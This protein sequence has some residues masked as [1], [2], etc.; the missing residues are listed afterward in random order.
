MRTRSH[1]FNLEC[2]SACTLHRLRASIGHSLLRCKFNENNGSAR[3][4]P[5]PMTRANTIQQ[6]LAFFEALA[7][8]GVFVRHRHVSSTLLV[9]T[10]YS[11]RILCACKC[12][13]KS[14]NTKY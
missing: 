7:V 11:Y 12:N 13:Q 3:T 5:M 6:P 9:L 14:Y 1:M 10:P 8:N 4:E 2:K